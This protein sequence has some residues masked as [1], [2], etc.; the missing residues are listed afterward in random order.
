[1]LTVGDGIAIFSICATI[2]GAMIYAKSQR[3]SIVKRMSSPSSEYVCPEHS[4]LVARISGIGEQIK[5]VKNSLDEAKRQREDI[6][7]K[8]D[9]VR[10]DIAVVV[11]TV[12]RQ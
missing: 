4:G 9:E 3:T 2:I 10:R 7:S 6:F 11:A 5:E 8:L 12:H 1:M